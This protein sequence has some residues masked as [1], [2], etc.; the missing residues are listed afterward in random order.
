MSLSLLRRARRQYMNPMENEGRGQ[1]Y[2]HWVKTGS[3]QIQAQEQEEISSNNLAKIMVTS[4]FIKG[5]NNQ[6]T[7][8]N[9]YY[10][11]HQTEHIGLNHI[12]PQK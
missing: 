11:H 3:K 2:R 9:H 5:E 4:L 1:N 12:K 6:V 10:H 8:N 7:M